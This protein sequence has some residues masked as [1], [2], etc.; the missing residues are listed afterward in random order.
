MAE[1]P[2]HRFWHDLFSQQLP[3]THLLAAAGV[4]VTLSLTLALLPN[5]NVE[6]N[7]KAGTAIEAAAQPESDLA[8]ASSGTAELSAALAAELAAEPQAPVEPALNWQQVTVKPGDSL[9]TLFSR[10]NLGARDV[11]NFV[12]S[13]KE[14]KQLKRIMPGETLSFGLNAKGALEQL[15][16]TKSQLESW[17]FTHD[18]EQFSAEHVILEPELQPTYRSAEITGSLFVAGDKVGIPH[19]LIME[20]AGI[21]GWDIDFA[22]D[23]RKGDQFSV[24]YEEKFLNGER[25][26]TGEILA[27]EFRNQGKTFK[28]VRYQDE[29]GR[30]S[31]YTPEGLSMRKAFLR[32]PVNFTR[33]SSNFNPRR[34]HPVTKKVRPHRGV[35]Y[36][37]PT[38]TPV[39]AAG[40]GKVIRSGYTSLNGNYVVIQHGQ[41]YSTKYLHLHKRK[42]RKGQSVRQ[43]QTIGTVGSTGRST[44]PH[45]HYEFLVNGVHRNPRTVKLPQALPIA[46]AKMATFQQQTAPLMATLAQHQAPQTSQVAMTAAPANNEG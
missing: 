5:E 34:L 27:A 23:I 44:G 36:A 20:L 40:D 24:L 33:V 6:A 29:D 2:Q 45:L 9:S 37:A 32:T 3:R 38:G 28:T 8:L 14:T 13:N 7:V 39:Y 16:Y 43:G 4:A 19:G 31:Y 21:F 11:H 41:K 17:Q 30:S 15:T 35:D 18:G 26:G 1:K 42:V 25:I 10:A 22:L 46:K 12:S